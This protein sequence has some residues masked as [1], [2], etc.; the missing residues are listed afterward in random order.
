MKR[1][2]VQ[3]RRDTL[4]GS[5]CHWTERYALV[6]ERKLKSADIQEVDDPLCDRFFGNSACSDCPL[7]DWWLECEQGDSPYN[8]IRTR[9]YWDEQPK[10]SVKHMA[11]VLCLLYYA[12]GGR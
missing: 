12:E 7:R 5:F 9:V 8:A 6:C 4:W 1:S 3:A 2:T 10:K 11:M